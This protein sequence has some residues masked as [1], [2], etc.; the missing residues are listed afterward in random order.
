MKQPAYYLL[1]I[2][3]L[4]LVWFTMCHHS[5]VSNVWAMYLTRRS[6]VFKYTWPGYYLCAFACT[7]NTHWGMQSKLFVMNHFIAQMSTLMQSCYVTNLCIAQIA[8]PMQYT[9][10]Y[11]HAILLHEKLLISFTWIHT[12]IHAVLLHKNLLIWFDLLCEQQSLNETKHFRWK[13]T[14]CSKICT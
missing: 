8:T 9:H 10:P 2:C 11:T 13:K 3:L 12:Y 1:M 5:I 4:P 14:F 7:I 6:F